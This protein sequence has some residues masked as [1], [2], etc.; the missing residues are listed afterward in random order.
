MKRTP[1]E[2]LMNPA[3]GS[4]IAAARDFGIDLTLLAENLKLTPAERVKNNDQL[5]NDLVK[6]ESAMKRAKRD[7]KV[8]SG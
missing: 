5:I 2:K 3:P 4:P 6:F 7:L 8:T 1:R